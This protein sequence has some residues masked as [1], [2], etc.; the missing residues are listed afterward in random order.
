MATLVMP[1]ICG[2]HV[3][4]GGRLEHL[5]ISQS[6]A[7]IE[8]FPPILCPTM[9]SGAIYPPSGPIGVLVRIPSFVYDLFEIHT[10][11]R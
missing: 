10:G 11:D 1:F 4:V 8:V 5:G 2:N 3:F 6:T 7:E 9:L